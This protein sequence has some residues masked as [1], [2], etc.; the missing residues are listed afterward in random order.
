[1]LEISKDLF[2]LCNEVNKM[3][4]MHSR[5]K[6]KSGSK[7]I[8]SDKNP[9]WIRYKTK[10]IEMLIVKLGKEGKTPSEIGMILRDTYGIPSVRVILKKKVQEVL[11]DKNIKTILPE[12]MTN[13]VKRAIAIRKHLETNKQDKTAKRGL[14][15][16]ES[17]IRRLTKYYKS[18]GV[19]E[20]T[21]NYNPKDASRY[22]Q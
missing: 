7:K 3:A 22:V 5:A 9:V 4:R 21:W 14:E 17:K 6:G 18:K 2:S 16:T 8:Y 10:E 13:L 19:I 11:E 20:K 15:L 12:D 1:M